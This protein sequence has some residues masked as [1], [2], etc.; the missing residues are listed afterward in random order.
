M[1]SGY[2]T[3]VQFQSGT[4]EKIRALQQWYST[5]FCKVSF[6]CHSKGSKCQQNIFEVSYIDYRSHGVRYQGVQGVHG[7]PRIKLGGP[8]IGLD[9]PDFKKN[10][11]ILC[12]NK[13][14][15]NSFENSSLV[16]TVSKHFSKFSKKFY[17]LRIILFFIYSKFLNILTCI[18]SFV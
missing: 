11:K 15:N 6:L 16:F 12:E 9:P 7:P 10:I 14:I 13:R 18:F 5:F 3:L 8:V 1:V 2:S 4:R 17:I